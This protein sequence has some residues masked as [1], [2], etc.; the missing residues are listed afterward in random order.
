MDMSNANAQ[1]SRL[2]Q[3]SI[4][5]IVVLAL[6]P[7]S[8]RRLI[9]SYVPTEYKQYFDLGLLISLYAVLFGIIMYRKVKKKETV[10][11]Y[12]FVVTSLVMLLLLLFFD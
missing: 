1:P 10:Y 11:F 8:L 6:G 5:W 2:S 4:I 9:I 12:P 3:K 7:I